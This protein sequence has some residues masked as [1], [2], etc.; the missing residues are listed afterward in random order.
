M[1]KE[2]PRELKLLRYWTNLLGLQDWRIVLETDVKPE[3]MEL[4]NADGCI[5][6][7]EVVK[8]AKIQIIDKNLREPS[9]QPFDFEETLVHELLHIK[10]C[11]LERGKKWEK[12]LQLRLLHQYVDDL[13]RAL[14]SAKHYK[15]K[16]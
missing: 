13:A 1:A 14:V 10:F 8:A 11:L 15:E 5:S 16:Q 3:N 9:L 7:E 2:M 6:Y 4:S 12:K